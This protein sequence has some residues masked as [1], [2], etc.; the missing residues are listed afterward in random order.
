MVKSQEVCL[1]T[2]DHGSRLNAA[3]RNKKK[4]LYIR[5]LFFRLRN[6]RPFDPQVSHVRLRTHQGLD[7]RRA[8]AV[9]WCHEAAYHRKS[10][11]GSPPDPLSEWTRRPEHIPQ[12]LIASDTNTADCVTRRKTWNPPKRSRAVAKLLL[13][14]FFLASS[15]KD[16]GKGGGS[17]MIGQQTI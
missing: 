13:L 15:T 12:T 8:L 9:C 6:R 10:E 3:L 5:H 1:V 14:F 11:T 16:R 4:N 17:G 2:G 7:L